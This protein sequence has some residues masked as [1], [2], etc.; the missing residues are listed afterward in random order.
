MK[1]KI[2]NLIV[3]D[4]SGSMC[5]IEKEALGSVNETIQTIRSAQKEYADQ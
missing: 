2:F 1:T 5:V 3:I 4:E